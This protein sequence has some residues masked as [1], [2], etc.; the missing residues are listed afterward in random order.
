MNVETCFGFRWWF[1]FGF[2]VS[3]F[4]VCC[5]DV[6]F[7]FFVVE[8]FSAASLEMPNVFPN[9]QVTK[10]VFPEFQD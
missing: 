9:Y 5:F 6:Y 1:G 8:F 10:L 3:R 2:Q 7:G 4:A